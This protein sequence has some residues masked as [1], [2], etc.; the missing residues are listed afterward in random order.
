M[1]QLVRLYRAGK[2]Y[3]K[4]Q[5]MRLMKDDQG[6]IEQYLAAGFLILVAA[7]IG[8]AVLGFRT[9]IISWIQALI[10]DVTGHTTQNPGF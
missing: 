1:F 9:Q 2:H 5:V 6:G 7:L 8:V 10:T 4:A 3:I